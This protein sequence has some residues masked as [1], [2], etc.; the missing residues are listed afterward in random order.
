MNVLL[1]TDHCTHSNIECVYPLAKA[2]KSTP[3]IRTITAVS[4][5]FGENQEA[6]FDLDRKLT[7]RKIDGGFTDKSA[8][9]WANNTTLINDADYDVV[10]LRIDRPFN[11]ALV[12][13]LE[14]RFP[15][16]KFVNDPFGI[17]NTCK[18]TSILGLTNHIA[19]LTLCEDKSSL[20][21]ATKLFRRTVL[22][23]NDSYGAHGLVLVE[24]GLAISRDGSS[25]SVEE[26]I[27]TLNLK[28][29]PYVA[30]EFLEG[31]SQGDNRLLVAN[32]SIVSSINRVPARDN[33]IS[34]LSAGAIAHVSKPTAEELEIVDDIRCGLQKE[35]I[36][37]FSAD[38]LVDNSGKRVLSEINTLNVGILPTPTDPS[39]MGG[40][41]LVAQEF[42][43]HIAI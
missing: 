24:N 13:H 4:R 27:E 18:K 16:A 29:E 15:S 35:G 8:K 38:T 17:I 20:L 32:G 11:V 40:A 34:N 9:C 33:W 42:I 25:I 28:T 19:P 5:S 10:F 2:L 30:V 39:M 3:K 1:L 6:L 43:R 37:I 23:P 36:F 7:G 22:K 26:F 12:E 41:T 21:E 31:V 14:K